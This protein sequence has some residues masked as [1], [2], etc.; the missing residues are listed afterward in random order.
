MTEHQ[1]ALEN[2][3]QTL[4]ESGV[5]SYAILTFSST[6]SSFVVSFDQNDAWEREHL[7]GMLNLC[8]ER[9]QRQAM[10]DE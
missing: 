10:G 2:A 4:E 1:R 8:E 9:V 5:E 6:D 3:S 7:V